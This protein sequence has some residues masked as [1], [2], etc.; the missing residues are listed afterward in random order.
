MTDD[1]Y[2][3]KVR[4]KKIRKICCEEEKKVMKKTVLFMSRKIFEKSIQA[5]LEGY[6]S[7]A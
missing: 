4:E 3:K 7:F 2:I 1:S 5:F 6:T